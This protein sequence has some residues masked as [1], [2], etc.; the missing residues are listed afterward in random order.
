MSCVRLTERGNDLQQ[1]NLCNFQLDV[2]FLSGKPASCN[3]LLLNLLL[4]VRALGRVKDS[5]WKQ[6]L[7][8]PVTFVIETDLNMFL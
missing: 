1:K 7:D 3:V 8:F 5:V 2:A 4:S 6:G